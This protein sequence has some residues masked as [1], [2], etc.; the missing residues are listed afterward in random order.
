MFVSTSEPS[1]PVP[2]SVVVNELSSFWTFDQGGLD[3]DCVVGIQAL[4]RLTEDAYRLLLKKIKN[5]LKDKGFL[6]LME[7]I[8]GVAELDEERNRAGNGRNM[9]IRGELHY[10]RIFLAHGWHMVDRIRNKNYGPDKEDM[11]T[12]VLQKEPTMITN[13]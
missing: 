9:M 2:R 7:P 12:F 11:L 10:L 3:Y 4:Y 8:L 1:A 6:I 5:V 13:V